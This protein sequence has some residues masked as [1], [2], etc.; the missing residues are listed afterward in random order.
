MMTRPSKTVPFR[1]SL[2]HARNEKREGRICGFCLS[3][4]LR[5]ASSLSE[6]SETGRPLKQ[7]FPFRILGLPFRPVSLPVSPLCYEGE[8]N[9]ARFASRFA[10]FRRFAGIETKRETGMKQ[11]L[12]LTNTM[13]GP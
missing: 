8:R 2:L 13:P 7:T 5:T 10:P 6:T 12:C 11:P 3:L 9:H 4:P 1:V